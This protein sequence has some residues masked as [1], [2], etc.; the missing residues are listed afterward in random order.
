MF[1]LSDSSGSDGL[2]DLDRKLLPPNT[3][4]RL[5]LR[6]EYFRRS[7]REFYIE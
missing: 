3:S 5:V 6:P 2:T 1:T 7:E 4:R